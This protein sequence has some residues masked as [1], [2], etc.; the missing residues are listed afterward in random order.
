MLLQTT[1]VHTA[2]K[3]MLRSE[4]LV[5][6]NNICVQLPVIILSFLSMTI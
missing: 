6:T 2:I 5:T 3:E 4:D 1:A